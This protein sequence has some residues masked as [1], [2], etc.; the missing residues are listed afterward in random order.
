MFCTSFLL[1]LIIIITLFSIANGN[2]N[3]TSI[4]AKNGT[5][6]RQ[7]DYDLSN[8]LSGNFKKIML[9]LMTDPSEFLA[10]TVSDCINK[11]NPIDDSCVISILCTRTK[12]ELIAIMNKYITISGQTDALLNQIDAKMS[13]DYKIFMRTML[14]PTRCQAPVRCIREK[15]QVNL[16][17]VQENIKLIPK[18]PDDCVV[19]ENNQGLMTM[20][21]KDSFE[22]LHLIISEYER[23]HNSSVTEAITAHCS[24]KTLAQ[25]YNTIVSY[26]KNPAGFY[27]QVLKKST[28]GFGTDDTTLIRTIVSRHEIDLA[29]IKQTYKQMYGTTL[30]ADVAGDTSGYYKKALLALIGPQ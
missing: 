18:K 5:Y 7:F 12:D 13:G 21:A 6:P 19:S 28:E 27:A 16:T 20:M 8:E 14:T 3:S 11:K 26:A 24:D 2:S 17:L 15:G 30:A 9:A 23:K 10:Q 25:A 22:Q 4:N 1:L 29:E